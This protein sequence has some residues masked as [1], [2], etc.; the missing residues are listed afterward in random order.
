M[1][2]PWQSALSRLRD[3]LVDNWPIKLTALVLAAIVW[4]AV[5]AEEPT[6][7]LVPV[8]LVVTPPEGR[9][10]V[11]PMPEVRGLFQGTARELIKLYAEPP[12]IEVTLPDTITGST[13][14]L[15]LAVGDIGG[16]EAATVNAQ[17]IEPRTVTISLD[18]IAH[19]MVPV[20][21]RVSVEPDSGYVLVDGVRVTPRTLEIEGP[22][23]QVALVDTLYTVDM[24]LTAVTSSQERR[25][26]IDTTGLSA[27]RPATQYV[28]ISAMVE[29]LTDRVFDAVR[30][31]VDARDAASWSTDPLAV[32]VTAHGVQSRIDRLTRDSVR[33]SVRPPA[34]AGDSVVAVEV[35]PLPGI[36]LTATPD[37]VVVRTHRP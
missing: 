10:I 3:R 16:L 34:T 18:E 30:V 23:S 33:V 12:T 9:S 8:R 6:V 11:G 32:A 29:G 25:V 13:Y 5:A 15:A 27:V 20:V 35:E 4:A 2:T 22:Q 26:A 19:R 14:Q 28:T 1:A 36:A 21:H 17:Q 37:S 31:T 7:Q 24:A